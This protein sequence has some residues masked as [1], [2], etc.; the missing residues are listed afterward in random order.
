MTVSALARWLGLPDVEAYA[1]D[2]GRY[3]SSQQR[4]RAAPH[5]P[6]LETFG[7]SDATVLD[8]FE[9]YVDWVRARCDPGFAR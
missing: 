7:L 5:A 1:A 9:P 8:H 2:I 4:I 6:K 3:L